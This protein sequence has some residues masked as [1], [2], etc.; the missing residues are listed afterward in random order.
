M[1]GFRQL[2]GFFIMATVVALLWVFGRQAGVNAMSLM[3]GSLVVVGLGTWIYGRGTAPI[4]RI[5]AA[6][7][8]VLGVFV[9]LS[10][11]QAAPGLVRGPAPAAAELDWEKWSAERQGELLAQGRPVFVDFTADWCLTCQVNEQ[12][13]FTEEVRDR[14]EAGDVALLRA[15][16]TLRDDAITRALA[17]HGRQGVPLYVLYDR[18]G[19]AR[20]LPQLLS[21]SIVLAAL[22]E[23]L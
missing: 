13:A 7:L 16:W 14:L 1:E 3:L 6:T 10:R 23:S 19:R 22:D 9:G 12:V 4:S 20:I 15:D 11:A 5:A 21:P 8:V 18:A 17:V 2:M